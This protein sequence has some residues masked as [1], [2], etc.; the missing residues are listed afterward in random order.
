V[1][2]LDR[3]TTQAPAQPSRIYLYAQEKW[4]KTSF[5]AHAPKPIFLMTAGETGL[6]D[7]INYGQIAPVPHFPDD[8]KA[9]PD[10]I[11]AV[12]ALAH[13]PH[14]YQ[15]L[16]IDT[17]NGAERLL[18]EWVL[19]EEF[20][21]VM[22]GKNGYGSYGKGDLACVRHWGEF[23]RELDAV[24]AR[25]RMSIVLLAHSRIKSVNNPEGDDY[26]QLRPEGIDKLWPLTHK[27]ASVIGGGTYRVHVKDDKA[28]GG[29]DRVVRLQG[30]A[31]VVAGNRYGLPETIAC[32]ATPKSAW[33]AFFGAIQAAKAKAVARPPQPAPAASPPPPPVQASAPA[34]PPPPPAAPPPPPPAGAADDADGG[35]ESPEGVPDGA[36][37][38][39]PKVGPDLVKSVLDLCHA[40]DQTWPDVRA[41][42]ADD[43]GLTA[44]P[45]AEQDPGALLS[46]RTVLRERAEEKA[47]R[48]RKKPEAAGVGAGEG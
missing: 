2:L 37:P 27:W 45:L 15:T 18:A 16:V 22:G 13:E 24:R 25:R 48:K 21:G 41:E 46:L 47:K 7:L 9:W 3:V 8:F 38:A 1:G 4:G 20:D 28:T 31:A 19:R 36:P 5:A 12:R 11:A 17:A 44:D 34:A 35:G 32:G 42:F 26:D 23:L 10:L 14:D 30:N 33:D 39:K 29:R 40:L 6:L 43:L